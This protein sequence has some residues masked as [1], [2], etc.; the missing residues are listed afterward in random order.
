VI[1]RVDGEDHPLNVRRWPLGNKWTFLNSS[2]VDLTPWAGKKVKVG[3]RYTSTTENASTWEVKN[4]HLEGVSGK[5]A[6]DHIEQ[7]MLD[8]EDTMPEEYFTIDGRRLPSRDNA[9]GIIIVKRGSY[10]SKIFI[11]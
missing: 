10:V 6:I 3:F 11:P 5:S 9:H 7:D 2:L 8:P 4:F 1:A